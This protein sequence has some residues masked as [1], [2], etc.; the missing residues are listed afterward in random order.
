MPNGKKTYWK[1]FLGIPR[2][3]IDWY[4]KYYMSRLFRVTFDKL[5]DQREYW[6]TRGAEYYEEVFQ[7]R[8]YDYEIFFQDMFV[9]E[10][11]QLSFESF[12]EAGCGFGWNVKRVKQEFPEVAIG[13][14]DFSLPQLI[15]SGRYLPE[16]F[17]PVVQGDACFMP[18]K[19]NAFDVGFTLGV[20]MN[21]HPTK[22]EKAID[23][24]IRVSK[25]YII[26]L[27]WDHDNTKPSLREKRIFKTNI[28]SHNYRQLYEQRGKNIL[29]FG[30]YKDFEDVFYQ[31]F[32]STA[33][34]TWEQFEGPEKYILLVVE[35]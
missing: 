20:F 35:L 21:I 4:F 9:N 27:E 31:R 15:N 12:F 33:V 2:Y 26:H 28:V 7:S 6:N 14:V 22:I 25:K 3:K 29:K 23:E 10:L 1:S 34:S 8:H 19:D 13:G 11:K 24:M 5:Q 30:T 17:M 18:F 32:R 16:I